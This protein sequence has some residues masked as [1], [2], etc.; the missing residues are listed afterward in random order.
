MNYYDPMFYICSEKMPFGIRINVELE[1]E[2]DGG[3]LEYAVNTAIRRYPYFAVRLVKSDGNIVTEKND[4]PVKVFKGRL[5]YPLGSGQVNHHILALSFSDNVIDFYMTHVMTDGAGFMPFVKSVLY[6]YLCKYLKTELPKGD[7]RLSDDPFFEGETENPY[8]EREMEQAVPFY[9]LPQKDFLRLSDCGNVSGDPVSYN[10][11]AKA[12]DVMKFSHENDASPCALFSSVMA[13][14]I[15]NVHPNETKD[16]VSAISFNMRPGLKAQSNYRMLC[17][18]IMVRYPKRLDTEDLGRVC[19]C[20]RGAVTV[21]SQPEDVLFYAQQQKKSLEKL[22]ELP[23]IK[24]KSE[25]LSKKALEDSV[26]NTFSVSYVGKIDYGSLNEHI[27]NVH[28]Y[29]DG[30]TYKTLFIEISSFGEWF[31]ITV[32]QGFSSDTYYKAMLKILAQNGI[33][34]IEEGAVL[35]DTPKIDLPY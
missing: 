23:D 6:Y 17:K 35:P 15:R 27:K 29:T 33:E 28:N 8:P 21:Q 9:R 7:I 22:L 19:T 16:I 30:S 20:T 3:I 14:A 24:S 34:Y 1:Y 25:V 12:S 2:I 10:F 26:N 32:L 5:Q 18:A 31:Y 13:K 4:L 11:R